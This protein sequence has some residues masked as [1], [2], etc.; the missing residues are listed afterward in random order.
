MQNC[1]CGMELQRH[2]LGNARL[3]PAMGARIVLNEHMI[4]EH[5][6]KFGHCFRGN[7]LAFGQ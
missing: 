7:A 6:A 3:I 5:R 2:Q 4:A 1:S